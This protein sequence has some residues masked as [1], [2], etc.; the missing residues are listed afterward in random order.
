MALFGNKDKEPR[1]A[2]RPPVANGAAPP[3]AARAAQPPAAKAAKA[4]PEEAKKAAAQSQQLL[5]GVGQIMTVLM[6]AP[7]FKQ[8]PLGAVQ[9]LVLPAVST[10]QFVVALARPGSGHLAPIAVALWATVSDDVDRRLSAEL[11]KPFRIAADE[12]KSGP[13]PWLILLAGDR[14]AIAPMLA[15]VQKTTLGGRELKTRVAN[16]EGKSEVRTFSATSADPLPAS[17]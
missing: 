6:N 16:A 10:G 15:Q 11:D 13:H 14:R 1:P 12:W 9:A 5:L 7:Q 17:G 2:A 4:S 8:S 3:P